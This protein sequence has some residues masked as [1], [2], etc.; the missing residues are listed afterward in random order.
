MIKTF[1][2]CILISC[3]SVS[4]I[5]QDNE[6]DTVN[7]GYDDDN[8]DILIGRAN[9]QEVINCWRNKTYHLENVVII[10]FETDKLLKGMYEN[11]EKYNINDYLRRVLNKVNDNLRQLGII[12]VIKRV[13]I[14]E[15]NEFMHSNVPEIGSK[16]KLLSGNG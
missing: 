10:D 5:I 2:I 13:I 16:L 8:L 4:V 9:Y 6:C 1:V 7:T 14:F 3:S 15:E 12:I 11:D